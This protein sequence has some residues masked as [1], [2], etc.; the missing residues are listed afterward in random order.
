MRRYDAIGVL[1]AQ[2]GTGPQL[3]TNQ[4]DFVVALYPFDP[5]YGLG[6]SDF[7]DEQH[8]KRGKNPPFGRHHP[9]A[10]LCWGVFASQFN[11]G[12]HHRGFWGNWFCLK[13]P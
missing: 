5:E 1:C 9:D 2:R 11:D 4:M 6:L 12:L 13:T 10:Q 3:F 7:C 8:H